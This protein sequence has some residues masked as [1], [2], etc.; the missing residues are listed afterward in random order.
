[1]AFFPVWIV[2]WTLSPQVRLVGLLRRDEPHLD[3]EGEPLGRALAQAVGGATSGHGLGPAGTG[4]V[5]GEPG[6]ETNRRDNLGP[7][8]PK[9]GLNS[10]DMALSGDECLR[11]ESLIYRPVSAR[12][13]WLKA[14]RNEANYVPYLARRAMDADDIEML[15][16]LEDQAREMADM[17]EARWQAEGL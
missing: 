15:E 17:V 3:Q 7:S 11:L 4:V 13:D 1:M 9:P 14:W 10:G 8:L 16:E 12:P 6:I 2:R 5:L